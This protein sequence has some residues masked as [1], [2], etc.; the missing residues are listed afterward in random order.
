MKLS[1]IGLDRTKEKTPG[2][3]K[4]A[5]AHSTWPSGLGELRI[6]YTFKIL[7]IYLYMSDRVCADWIEL[8]GSKVVDRGHSMH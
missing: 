3:K 6:S 1:V 4:M 2:I 7:F 5:C 8:Y